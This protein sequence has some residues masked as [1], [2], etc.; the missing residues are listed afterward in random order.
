[1]STVY[2]ESIS[3]NRVPTEVEIRGIL[4]ENIGS[5]LTD[6]A[7]GEEERRLHMRRS[8]AW[9][10][11]GDPEQNAGAGRGG[12]VFSSGLFLCTLNL[13]ICIYAILDMSSLTTALEEACPVQQLMAFR[14]S[15][16]ICKTFL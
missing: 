16:S 15:W 14:S 2:K 4:G 8:V 1:M 5:H 3:K 12:S 9:V 10:S 11:R 13:S 6:K 7:F